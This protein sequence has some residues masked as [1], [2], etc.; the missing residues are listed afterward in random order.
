MRTRVK[1]G[2]SFEGSCTGVRPAARAVAASRAF[3]TKRKGRSSASPSR[4]DVDAMPLRP[5][6]PEPRSSRM[7]TVSAWS[8][9]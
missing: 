1:R 8:S 6:G 4:S 9:R 5:S 3:G 7:N 2:S